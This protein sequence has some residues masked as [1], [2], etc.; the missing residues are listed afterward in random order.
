[1]HN[2]NVK[3]TRI[4]TFSHGLP[5]FF[6]DCRCKKSISVFETG[7]KNQGE[8]QICDPRLPLRSRSDRYPAVFLWNFS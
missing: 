2:E 1:M 3:F 6:R 4:Q 7:N 8:S 5:H